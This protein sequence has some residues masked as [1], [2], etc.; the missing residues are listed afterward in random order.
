MVNHGHFATLV[1][2]GPTAT[3]Q[4]PILALHLTRLKCVAIAPNCSLKNLTCVR[5]SPIIHDMLR[6]DGALSTRETLR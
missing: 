2:S 1:G 3:R 5:R 4:A 6:V